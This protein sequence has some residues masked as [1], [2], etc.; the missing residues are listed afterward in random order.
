[1]GLRAT[2]THSAAHTAPHSR[3]QSV[4]VEG[5]EH[6]SECSSVVS[7]ADFC[8]SPCI[9]PATE[10]TR[11]TPAD[12][13]GASSTVHPKKAPHCEEQR[14]RRAAANWTACVR[15]GRQSPAPPRQQAA[16]PR[17]E[18]GAERSTERPMSLA[19]IR[20]PRTSR[21]LMPIGGE[22]TATLLASNSFGQQLFF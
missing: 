12:E 10:K 5:G 6:D 1:M 4:C 16:V 3:S 20:V 17:P 9:L 18:R 8:K 2:H 22:R 19:S 13:A 11:S 15:V 21:R 7:S 14:H